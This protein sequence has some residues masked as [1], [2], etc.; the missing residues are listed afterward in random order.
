MIETTRKQL[1]VIGLGNPGK[2]Y[3][4]TRHNVGFMVLHAFA[5]L[6]GW[7]YKEE[8][9]FD[10]QVVKG[11]IDDVIVH[12]LLPLTYM[13]ESGRAVRRY[14]D[15]YRLNAGDVFVV[16]DDVD[17]P[18]GS[19]RLRLEGSAGGHNGLKSLEKHLGTRNYPRLRIGVGAKLPMQDLADHVLSQFNSQEVEQLGQVIDQG[20]KVVLRMVRQESVASIMNDVN[21]KVKTNK[22]GLSAQEGQEKQDE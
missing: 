10:A 3:E 14:L 2:K 4:T 6:M 9:R 7:S 8:K 17:Q 19:M 15:F 16:S 12:L 20:V 18:L 22:P 11:Q 1:V 13:N 21:K 5:A